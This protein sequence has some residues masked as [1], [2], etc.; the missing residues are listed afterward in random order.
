MKTC[1]IES[2]CGQ[3]LAKELCRMHYLRQYRHGDPLFVNRPSDYVPSGADSANYK[4]GKWNHPLY[5]TWSNMMRRCYSP[6]DRAYKNY[7][8][9]GISVCDRWHDILNFIEDMGE[10]PEGH[11]IDR[12]D[13]NS[14]YS[15]ENC[16]WATD[17]T[18]S[19]NRRY[20]KLNEQKASEIRSLRDLGA[21]R[22]ELAEKFGVS[23]ATIK[24]VLSGVYWSDNQQ[25]GAMKK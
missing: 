4:H 12:I 7:G 8:A 19:R 25:I 21:K 13:N 14:G 16:R 18:Q 9:R 24:K 5:K 20:A 6:S 22:K 1:K 15:K 11:S 17:T 10:R 23:L 3:V 2:C